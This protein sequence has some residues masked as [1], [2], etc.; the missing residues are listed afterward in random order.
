MLNSRRFQA[1]L[2]AGAAMLFAPAV[3]WASDVVGT[4]TDGSG[5]RALQGAEVRIVELGRVVEAERDG[6]FHFGDVP[7]GTYTVVARYVGTE[8]TTSTITVPDSGNVRV[9]LVLGGNNQIIVVGQAAS[10]SSSLSRQR[11]ADGVESV[12][13]RDSIGQFPDQNVAESLRRLPGVNILN[14][15]GEGRFVSVR[16]LDPELNSASIN[17]ARLPA[18]ESDVRSV[19]LDVVPSELIESI[20]VKKSLTPDMDADTLGASIEINTVSAFDRKKDLLS[21]KLEGSY[22]DYA[23]DVTPKASL[24]FSTKL[25]DTFGIAGGVSYYK[26]KFET[27]NIEGADWNKA[28]GIVYAEELQY[29]D[30]NVERERFGAS[31][32]LDWRLSDTTKLYARGLYSS[33]ADQEYRGDVIFIM[34]GAPRA[35]NSSA[36]SAYFSSAD[37]RIEVRRR[38]KDRYEEQKI[39][40]LTIGGET[41]AGPWKFTYSGAYSEASEYENGS[42]DPTRFRGRF[43]GTGA[44]AVN[45]LFDY[46]DVRRPLFSVSGNTAL[47]NSADSYSFNELERTDLSDSLDKEWT[48]RADLAREFALARGTFTLQAGAKGRWRTKSYDFNGTVY[49]GYTGNYPLSSVLGLPTYRIQAITPQLGHTAPTDFFNA[50]RANFRVNRIDTLINSASSD[51]SIDEDVMAGYLLGRLDMADL[52]VIGGVRME[53]THN[54]IGAFVT[55]TDGTNVTVTPNRVKRNYTDWLPSLT[56]RYEPVRNIVLRLGGYKSLV[57]P[58]LSNL[59]P[60]VLVNEDDEAE[61]GNPNLKPYRAWNVDASAEWYFGNGS[62]LTAGVFWKSIDDFIV[63]VRDD[64]AGTIYGVP[65]VQADT[66]VNGE[67]AKVKG[68]ELSYAQRFTFLPAPFDGLLLNANY[69]FTDAK[70]TVFDGDNLTDPRRISLPSAARNTF[71]VV[72]GYEKGRVSF[73]AAGTYRDKYLDE[74]GGAPD[75]DRYVDQHFQLD[76]SAKFKMTKGV[77][78][79]ADWVNVTDAPYFA[80]QNYEGAKRLLQYEKYSWTAKF[81]V[82]ANF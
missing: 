25:S 70:G 30:Y 4:V 73:R 8:P 34:S 39:K 56:F 18:P 2:L 53:R 26:R 28:N 79:F 49:D 67:T 32:N 46:A 5:T 48:G 57:R 66:F 12:L 61:F 13:T 69:T 20:E 31:L 41:E 58:K 65:Y 71:N 17:G 55:S 43:S 76:L 33:F 59:A 23:G 42:I 74:L 52:R 51:Y 50:N 14:D 72:L 45:L 75:E 64:N 27:D 35:A 54:D 44:N 3:A 29:R 19:A 82:S 81:G 80:Y 37:G 62:A 10:L 7:A 38:M 60:R 22:N 77:R 63:T 40:S 21:I 9:D 47:F 15:Q 36:N 11:A 1:G 78:L 68:V 16:G 24:D 6:S